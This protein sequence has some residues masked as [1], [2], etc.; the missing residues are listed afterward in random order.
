MSAAQEAISQS[1]ENITGSVGD[2]Q[3]LVT[4]GSVQSIIVNAIQFATSLLGIVAL[5]VL[6]WAGFQYMT[7]IGNDDQM[8]KAKKTAFWAVA[9]L[10][11]AASS[12]L[13]LQAISSVF[14]YGRL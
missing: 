11:V 4:E 10:V 13:I 2:D 8:N 14:L 7:S 6:I 1:L 5:A 12:F 9:G 3:Y